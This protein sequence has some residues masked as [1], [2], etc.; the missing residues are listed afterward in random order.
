MSTTIFVCVCHLLFITIVLF[1][2]YQQYYINIII[3]FM[4]VIC[5]V[6]INYVYCFV[7]YNNIIVHYQQY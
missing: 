6:H 7:V 2:C 5:I 3:L 4:L 1:V